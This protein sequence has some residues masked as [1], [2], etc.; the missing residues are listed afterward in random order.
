MIFFVHL[1]YKQNIKP[2]KISETSHTALVAALKEA[3]GRYMGNEENAAVTDIHL[4]PRQDSGEL[5]LFND[6]DE[7]LARTVVAEWSDYEGDD[8]YLQT[9]HLLRS[10]LVKLKEEGAFNQL[11]LLKPYSFVLVDEDKETVAELL[12]LDEEDTLLLSEDL[13]KGLDE[14]LDAFLND[15]LSR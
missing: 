11:N 13:L 14:E 3:L 6:D 9:E 10:L 5:L 4:Q 7:E 15:L 8:F 2:M 12:L 1:K